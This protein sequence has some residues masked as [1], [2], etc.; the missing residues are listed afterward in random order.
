MALQCGVTNYAKAMQLAH[1]GLDGR[2]TLQT[3][4]PTRLGSTLFSILLLLLSCLS[5]YTAH[6]TLA[7]LTSGQWLQAVVHVVLTISLLDL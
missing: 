2:A 7:L 6:Q 1:G 5:L 3:T 4:A